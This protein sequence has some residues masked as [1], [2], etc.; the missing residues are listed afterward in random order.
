MEATITVPTVTDYL[1]KSAPYKHQLA[2][3]VRSREMEEFAI[4]FK[5]G[6][7]KSKV[8]VDTAA[9]LYGLGRID[10]L[11]ILA[12]N[13]VHKKWIAED[14]PL[15]LPDH[16]EVMSAFW[17]SG[18]QKA[19]I[20]C[21][22]LLVKRGH[23]L[24]I[25]CVNVEALSY[26]SI[27][28]YLKKFLSTHRALVAVDESTRIKN[29]DSA[30]TKALYKLAPLMPYRRI[31]TGSSV[32]QSP[33]DLYGQFCFLNPEILGQ[34]YYAYKA[35]YA[36]LKDNS[37]RT[38]I[39][40]RKK[41]A[42][43]GSKRAG[44]PIQVVQTDEQGQPIY[45]NLDRLRELIAPHSMIVDK[46]D[47]IDLPPKVYQKRFCEL[48]H[49]T[50]KVYDE[51]K[52]TCIAQLKDS[53]VS[54]LHKMVMV[55][56]L[57]QLALG[58]VKDDDRVVVYLHEKPEDNPRI[59]LLLETLEDIE[60]QV[61][62][63]TNHVPAIKQIMTVL[64]DQ[65]VPYFGEVST[66]QREENLARFKSGEV[67]CLIGTP[68]TGGIGLNMANCST[69][70]YYSNSYHYEDRV[71]SED[72]A[73]RIGQTAEFVNY[74]D[75]VADNTVDLNVLAALARKEDLANYIQRSEGIDYR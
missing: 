64:G 57:H 43:S 13:G 68:K 16:I 56:K 24:K 65:A 48:D 46:K 15:S 49:K 37:D 23:M 51:L 31:L 66:A 50:R 70:V 55:T 12:P 17:Q 47:A 27:F 53:T 34:S 58:F 33:Y 36:E 39:A 62:I 71:Q 60:G 35:T 42:A 41:L 4:L 10:A 19:Q 8:I 5:M 74:I 61:I 3:F 54:V 14:V 26:K 59:Q 38:V 7:G 22:N 75:L 28:D 73:H 11:V 63:W 29:P 72:R 1:F 32:V 9:Y 18:N 20:A 67:R 52:S 2:C 6:L 69:V 40:I 45:K 30:R 44:V 21:T 25:L